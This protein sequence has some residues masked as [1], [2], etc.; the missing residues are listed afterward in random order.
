MLSGAISDAIGDENFAAGYGAIC[1]AA[2]F[3]MVLVRIILHK[4]PV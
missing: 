3:G 1:P 4:L 2:L